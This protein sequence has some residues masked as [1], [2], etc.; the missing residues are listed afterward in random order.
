MI[1]AKSK[2]TPLRYSRQ[3]IEAYSGQVPGSGPVHSQF[4]SADPE[5]WNLAW[6]SYPYEHRSEHPDARF[7]VLVF[8]TVQTVLSTGELDRVN[9]DADV[10]V[11]GMLRKPADKFLRALLKAKAYH[12]GRVV[13]L[14]PMLPLYQAY[15]DLWVNVMKDRV[16]ACLRAPVATEWMPGDDVPH[17]NDAKAALAKFM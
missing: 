13:P 12:A 5:A 6:L 10:L 4:L 11:R 7:T 16:H 1:D 8:Q 14:I 3:P 17:V 2:L 9:R 15:G